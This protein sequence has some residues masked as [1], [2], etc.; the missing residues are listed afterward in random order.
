MGFLINILL[1]IFVSLLLNDDK[2]RVGVDE[3]FLIR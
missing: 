1:Y 3:R 2:T